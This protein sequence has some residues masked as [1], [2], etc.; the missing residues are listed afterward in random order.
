LGVPAEGFVVFAAGEEE[1]G[2]LFAPGEG[3]DAFFVAC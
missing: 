3:E 1:V 2:V